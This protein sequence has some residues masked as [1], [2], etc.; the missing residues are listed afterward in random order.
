MPAVRL[1][2]HHGGLSTAVAALM[3]GTPQLILPW[4]LE[5]LVTARAV[6]ATGA[7]AIVPADRTDAKTLVRA[8]RLLVEDRDRAAKAEVAAGTV[9]LGDPEA[10]VS[11]V[12]GT[13][14]RLAGAT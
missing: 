4:N 10:G 5:H 11:A 9:D 13:V 6:E 7:A 12:V 14:R 3:A 8:I 2:I 1:V